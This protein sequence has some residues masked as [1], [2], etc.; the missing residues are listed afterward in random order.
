MRSTSADDMSTHA[1]SP[2]SILGG[3][4]AAA[5][6]AAAGASL[7]GASA[8]GAAGAAGV[9]GAWAHADVPTSASSVSNS[10]ITRQRSPLAT[11]YPPC[12]LALECAL[13]AFAG[14]DPDRR[15]DRG[16]EDLSV[17]DIPGLGRAREHARNFV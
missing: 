7:L 6:A 8:A 17:S 2:V 5:G 11:T 4:G 14:T 10:T 16:D 12:P 13:V 1:V 15:V 3:A 9:A